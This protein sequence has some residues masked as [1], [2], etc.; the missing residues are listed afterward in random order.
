VRWI[1]IVGGRAIASLQQPVLD[2]ARPE[3]VERMLAMRGEPVEV[4]GRVVH[5]MEPPQERIV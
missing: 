1:A 5:A 3:V 4:F 2:R